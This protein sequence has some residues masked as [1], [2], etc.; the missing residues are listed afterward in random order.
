MK[1]TLK[2][3]YFPPFLIEKI[4]KSNLDKLHSRS[5][6]SKPDFDKTRFCKLQYIWKIFKA[7]SEKEKSINSSAKMLTLLLL[8]LINISQIK[9][10]HPIFEVFSS[11]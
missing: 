8:I 4:T 11:L 7:S 6:Q 2:R 10:K 1:E 5:G 3:N 9:I